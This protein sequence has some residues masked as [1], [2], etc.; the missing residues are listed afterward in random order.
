MFSVQMA[1]WQRKGIGS[2]S[3]ATLQHLMAA[4]ASGGT[5]CACARLKG[6]PSTIRPYGASGESGGCCGEGGGE[7]GGGEGGG[8][9]TGG[10]GDGDGGE[11]GG[12]GGGGGAVGEPCGGFGE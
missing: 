8:G 1:S 3:S 2:P 6:Q 5:H 12:F 9:G 7:G 10:G 11:G 4:F